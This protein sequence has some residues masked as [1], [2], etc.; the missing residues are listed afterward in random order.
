LEIVSGNRSMIVAAAEGGYSVIRLS[1]IA[2]NSDQA[3]FREQQT[4]TPRRTGAF[5]VA[6]ES[7]GPYDPFGLIS[8]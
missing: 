1:S 8:V 3:V 6:T 5:D 7:A 4:K 2:A